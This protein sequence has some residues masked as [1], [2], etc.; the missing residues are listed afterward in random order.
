VCCGAVDQILLELLLN[1]AGFQPVARVALALVGT[2][3]KAC[4]LVLS[5]IAENQTVGGTL[6]FNLESVSH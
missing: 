1:A 5:C 3:L 2:L 6:A 4:E